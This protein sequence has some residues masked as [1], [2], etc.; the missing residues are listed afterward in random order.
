MELTVRGVRKSFPDGL[1]LAELMVLEK[2]ETPEYVTVAVND[3][4]VEGA[5]VAARGLKDGDSLEFLYFMGGG[6]GGSRG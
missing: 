4:F 1:S 3:E 6:A 5:D 2:V